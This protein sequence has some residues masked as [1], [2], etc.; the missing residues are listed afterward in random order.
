LYGFII[1]SYLPSWGHL[2]VVGVICLGALVVAFFF[3]SFQNLAVL[4]LGIWAGLTLGIMAYEAVISHIFGPGDLKTWEYRIT[5]IVF[6]LAGVIL[7]CKFATH[8]IVIA[9]SVIGAYCVVRVS[10]LNSKI[11][12][13]RVLEF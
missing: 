1:P 10:Y 6:G 2:V 3:S 12:F 13:F 9:S 4:A 8:T 11:S 7:A 5:L